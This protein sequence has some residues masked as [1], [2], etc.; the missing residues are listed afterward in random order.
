M[1]QEEVALEMTQNPKQE[2]KG[3]NLTNGMKCYSFAV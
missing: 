2:H 3:I 1:I